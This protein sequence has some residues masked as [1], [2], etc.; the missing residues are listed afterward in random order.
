MRLFGLMPVLLLIVTASG[1]A[2]TSSSVKPAPGFSLDNIDKSVDPCVDFYQYACGNW[3]KNSEIPPDQSQ[4]VSFVELRERNLDIDHG[5]LDKAAAGGASRDAVDQRIGDLYGS[6]M[7]EEAVNAKG[8][9]PLKPEL[10]RVAA[11]QDK[12]ALIDEL[13]HLYLVGGTSLFSFYSSSD[14]HNADQVIAYIDQGG[15][16]LPDRDY[17]IKEDNAK[18]KEMRQH[19]VEYVTQSFTLVGQTSQQA[20]DSAQTVLRIETA[21]AKASMDR[22]ARRDPKNRDHKMTR[23]EAV[24][25]GPDFYLNRYFAAVGAPN[26]TQLNVTNP[27]FFK[28]VNGVLESESLDSLKTYVSW[29]VLNAAEPWLS[30]PFVDVN[31]KF[32]QNLT[33]QKEIQA[34][35][36]RCVSLTDQELGEALGQ[37]YVDATFGPDGKQRM[38]KMVD[39]LEKSLADDIQGL[40]WMSDE[41]KKQ[42]KV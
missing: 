34:R 9:A 41:T 36:K 4:W 11:V 17:Y 7:D 1:F 14:L 20:A 22:T 8:L 29:H 28:Q 26:F 33:G 13:A 35:W 40:S 15:L 38:L 18:M 42:A 24:A 2:Q 25:L 27:D 3:I 16:T 23:D 30:Q 39:A 5:I 19:L 12:A 31:F 32:Q 37:R 21:L 10:N 6:C